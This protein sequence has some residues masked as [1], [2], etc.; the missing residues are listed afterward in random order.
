[1]YISVYEPL[2]TSM[3]L[4]TAGKIS[5]AEWQAVYDDAL[6]LMEEAARTQRDMIMV[7]LAQPDTES[8]NANWRRKLA[9]LRTKNTTNV[10]SLS[11][12]VTPS[13]L[14]GGVITAINW[15]TPANAREKLVTK[16]TFKEALD[17]LQKETGRPLEHLV[18]MHKTAINQWQSKLYG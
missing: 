14:L 18:V 15:I 16:S 8:P 6:R 7:T 11:V 3:V 9:E 12:I 1:M 4:I 2:Q 5:D 13:L 17:W 10:R